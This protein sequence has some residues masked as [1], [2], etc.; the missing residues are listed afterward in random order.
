M[1]LTETTECVSDYVVSSYTPTINTLLT[2][3]PRAA[4]PFEM[5]VVTQD[6]VH[7]LM[8]APGTRE[9]L[10]IIEAYVPAKYLVKLVGGSV[11]DA[12]SYLPR[13]AIAHFACHGEQVKKNPPE[14]GLMFQDGKLTVSDIMHLSLPNARLAFLSADETATGDENL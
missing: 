2:G 3:I 10:R 13:A 1:Y 4:N 5:M 7:G 6:H 9:E 8:P 11:E 14:S 12:V